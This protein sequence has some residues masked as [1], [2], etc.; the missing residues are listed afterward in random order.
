MSL[1][2]DLVR[3]PRRPLWRQ[4]VERIA[5]LVDEGTLRPGERLPPTRSLARQLGVDRST[6]CRAYEELWALGYVQG[7]QGG[8][9][10]VRARVRTARATT[11]ARA[12]QVDWGRLASPGA[13]AAWERELVLATAR[14]RPG[15]VDFASLAADPDLCPVDDFRRAV[16]CVL[17][18]DGRRLLDYGDPAGFPPLRATLARR[19]RAHGIEV[20]ADEVLVTQGAQHGL[21]LAVRLL[22]RPGD[23]VAVE[24]PT[25]GQMLALLRL[26]DV[27][28]LDVPL[29]ESGLDLD[30]LERRLRRTR[31]KL[32]YTVPSFHNPT[33]T[34]TG[35]AHRE[36]L[37]ALCESR[38]VPILE[39]GFEE[40]LK[41]FGRAALP[42]K[43]MDARGLVL[44]VGTLSKTVFPGLRLGWI[45]AETDCVRRLA[46]LNRATSLSGNVVTQAAVERFLLAGRYDAYLRR[47]HAT[48][49]R[50][51]VALL[52]GLAAHVP[53]S[54][55][56]WTRPTGGC[57]VWGRVAGAGPA[58]EAELVQQAEACGVAVTPGSG[59]FP[60]KA[61]G[62]YVR[63]SI[64]NAKLQDIEEGCRRL[65]RALERLSVGRA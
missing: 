63:L 11:R 44:Y 46:A 24:V 33:G 25:Y 27:R 34:A 28:T 1:L 8:Y 12:P 42:I 58:A 52:R 55:L 40:D 32:L 36:R 53:E 3:G 2:F 16:R 50:R 10:T 54:R 30:V 15:V 9:T 49:R 18:E 47:L 48:L 59:F 62:L 35:Q 7:R 17:A 5:R 56:Q 22:C 60:G 64:A 13:R 65:A 41:Y 45:A 23:T 43:S 21:D 37:L 26:A 29:T 4:I 39:D 6:V 31:P 20:S 19:L 61:D 57:T 38:G 51:M 14:P